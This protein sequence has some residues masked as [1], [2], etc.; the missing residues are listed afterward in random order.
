MQWCLLSLRLPGGGVWPAGA[1]A[2]WARL[3]GNPSRVSC[4]A[5]LDGS[6]PTTRNPFC[7]RQALRGQV[8]RCGFRLEFCW[9]CLTTILRGPPS[10]LG[11]S[12]DPLMT[13]IAYTFCPQRVDVQPQRLED[14][15]VHWKASREPW[16]RLPSATQMPA[17]LCGRLPRSQHVPETRRCRWAADKT[18]AAPKMP[19]GSPPI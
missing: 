10:G 2:C 3:A 7:F 18:R 1:A 4:W 8:V 12:R 11:P 13:P 17:A 5:V 16:L 19:S 6:S 9:C 15:A 14:F